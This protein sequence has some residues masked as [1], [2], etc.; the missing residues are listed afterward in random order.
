M[1]K[2]YAGGC[3]VDGATGLTLRGV[4]RKNGG[5]NGWWEDKDT[6]A[7][8]EAAHQGHGCTSHITRPASCC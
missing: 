1:P 7:M 3:L 6:A 4:Q 5:A 2:V 8:H